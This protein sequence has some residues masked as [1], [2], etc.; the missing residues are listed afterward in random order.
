MSDPS[1][2][3]RLF[4]TEEPQGEL[5]PLR[6]GA[7]ECTLDAGN[8]RWIRIH[9]REAI[10]AVAFVVRDRDWGTYNPA[11]DALEVREEPEGFVVAYAARCADARQ[12]L[13]YRA[14]ITGRA[15]GRLVFEAEAVPETDFET[16]R[17]GFVVLHPIAGMPGRPVAIEHTDGRR[18]DSRFPELI[19]PWC[20]FEDVR[21]MRHEVLPGLAVS[22][23][24][25]G[26]AYETEDQ[27]NWTDASFKTYIRPLR[28]PWPYV[29][30]RGEP[31]VQRV[32]LEV[33][34]DAAPPPAPGNG[35][36]RITLRFRVPT[37]RTVPPLGLGVLPEQVDAALARA[38]DLRA[39]SPRHLSCR[40]DPRRGHDAA[41]LR[42]YGELGLASGTKLL[43]EAVVPC[44]DGAG[45][46]TADLAVLRR[47]LARIRD[48]LDAAGVRFSE[49][50]VSLGCD[51]KCVL[52]GSPFPPA[53]SWHQFVAAA[54]EIL[55]PAPLGGG[56][57]AFFTELNRKRPPAGL[58]DF[59]G[60]YTCPIFHAGD[61][62]S[63]L[64]TL[65]TLPHVF[66]SARAFLGEALYR[67]YPTSIVMRENPYGEAP[68]A[69]PQN[70]RLAMSAV[71]PRERAL[72]GAAWYAGYLARVV[73]EH[74]PDIVTMAA[75]VGPAGI[76]FAPA[77]WP[78][79]WFDEVRPR[80]YPK[81]H[82]LRGFARLAG[83]RI[84]GLDNP[85]PTRVLAFAV[86][87]AGRREAWIAHLQ[88]A[89]VEVAIEGLGDRLSATVL[90]GESF[91]LAC[92]DPEAFDRLSVP[93][94]DGRLSLS[95][96]AVAR[97]RS[98]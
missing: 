54:R 24:M 1:Q 3:I 45:R 82:V 9:G 6:A 35:A 86:D 74:G 19:S 97:V 22:C 13:R 20:P 11:I 62:A 15:D 14:R 7:L 21:A 56:A 39:A 58:F 73:E 57:F 92:R 29:L 46:P 25:E 31:I 85:A 93:L 69:N 53:P 40:F 91:S 65:E 8:L 67:L 94:R 87:L 18:E 76:V 5:R 95:A 36:D 27:R 64:E 98:D 66:R 89:P 80:V 84:L 33:T 81:Y 38:P 42:R 52:P 2:A 50:A 78:Q 17:T 4:G 48:A 12:A 43:L 96:F 71:D 51:M 10:R 72:L 37:H 60:H 23:R 90:D 77:D 47:D 49:I 75:P 63:L 61:D 79:P 41:T 68:A 88:A 26:D 55:P 30:P 44:E 28:K 70:R 34:G 16:N 32:S 59:V 83:A